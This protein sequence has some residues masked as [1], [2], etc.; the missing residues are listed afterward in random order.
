MSDGNHSCSV[1]YLSVAAPA[2]NEAAGIVEV[3]ESWRG[4]L[5]QLPQL[6]GFEIVVCNDGSKDDTGKLL[7]QLAQSHS[8]IRPV[9]HQ[10]N[11]GAA[12]ALTTAI[13]STTYPW[14]LLIDSDGQYGVDPIPHLIAAIEKSASR[15]AIGVRVKKHDSMLARFG[16]WASGWL[17]NFFHGTRYRDFN[18]ALKLVDGQILRSL[19]LEAKGLNYSADI[20]S[21]LVEAGVQM[22]EVEVIHSPRRT[23]RSSANS[24]AIWHRILFVGL[25]GYRQFLLRRGVIQSYRKKELSRERGNESTR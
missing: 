25:L 6:K 4:Y 2:Y 21:R 1:E 22:A 8:Q 15:A 5:S 7:D 23:G 9:H 18:C 11:R 17:C 13:D 12:A 19:V 24:K 10:V 16:S 14:V 3:V 20:S